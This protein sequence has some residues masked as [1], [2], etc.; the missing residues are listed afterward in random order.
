MKRPVVL[1][2]L[3][4]ACDRAAGRTHRK[5]SISIVLSKQSSESQTPSPW[6]L[7]ISCILGTNSASFPPQSPG[8]AFLNKKGFH[9]KRLDNIERVRITPPL[10]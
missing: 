9:T 7:D 10:P 3:R 8:L 1:Q 6:S 5:R 2:Y 4:A